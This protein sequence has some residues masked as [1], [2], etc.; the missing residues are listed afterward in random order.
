MRSTIVIALSLFIACSAL[1]DTTIEKRSIFEGP[2]LFHQIGS[3]F[4]GSC[5]I[6][7]FDICG[8]WIW[9]WE[10]FQG[11][12]EIGV[13]FDLPALCSKEVGGDCTNN[14][15]W[16]YWRNTLPGRGYT[17][18]YEFWEVDGSGC[19]TGSVLGS[20]SHD[21]A[22]GW[23]QIAGIGSTSADDVAIIAVFNGILPYAVSDNNVRNA[24]EIPPCAV[25]A[26]NSFQFSQAGVPSCPPT[27]FDDVLGPVDLMVKASFTCDPA[28][29]SRSESWGGVKTLF[30]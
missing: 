23:N 12:D 7:Q 26:A 11:G 24:N 18:R 5:T 19:K 27:V 3:G 25:G 22:A 13:V 20:Y 28:S 29:A 6:I 16:W 4:A 30:R 21:P 8:G 10:G 14:A 1:A 9:Q 17:V 2:R 15:I